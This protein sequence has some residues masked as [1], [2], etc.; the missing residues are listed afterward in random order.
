MGNGNWDNSVYVSE[1]H[2]HRGML[3]SSFLG[4]EG[5]RLG[6]RL[7]VSRRYSQNDRTDC[8]THAEMTNYSERDHTKSLGLWVKCEVH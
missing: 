5:R 4:C 3:H 8:G 7:H 6:T 2:R 1:H